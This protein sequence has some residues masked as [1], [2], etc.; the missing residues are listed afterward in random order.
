M[1]EIHKEIQE[2]EDTK[3]ILKEIYSKRICDDVPARVRIRTQVS[4]GLPTDGTGVFIRRRNP[5][6]C[7]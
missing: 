4:G 7:R 1:K 2:K 5:C 3:L 6:T